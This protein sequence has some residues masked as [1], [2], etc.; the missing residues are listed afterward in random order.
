VDG[1][2]VAVLACDAG[3]L[4][5]WDLT[6]G[7]LRATLVG[8][9]GEISAVACTRTGDRLNE[10]G[11]DRSDLDLITTELLT[12][13]HFLSPLTGALCVGPIGEIIT[14]VGWD[15]T[16]NNRRPATRIP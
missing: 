6:T 13:L 16:V 15:L 4:R 1:R 7:M 3:N 5:M 11:Q 9:E 14:G 10:Q 12:T 2:Q 8:H